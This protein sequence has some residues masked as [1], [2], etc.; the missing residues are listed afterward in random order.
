MEDNSVHRVG[1][2]TVYY[3]QHLI[4]C[5]I[6]TWERSLL[7]MMTWKRWLVKRMGHNHHLLV[8]LDSERRLD[9]LAFLNVWMFEMLIVLK[10]SQQWT[11]IPVG[12]F[13]LLD[14]AVASCPGLF[15][16]AYDWQL[17]KGVGFTRKWFTSKTIQEP[18][19]GHFDLSSNKKHGGRRIGVLRYD[20]L[21]RTCWNSAT[22][23]NISTGT[24][25]INC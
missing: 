13:S 15:F 11:K 18:R 9:K 3:P 7:S 14:L 20:F 5:L 21:C 19:L 8:R 1:P 24:T 22:M 17:S 23:H 4:L 16:V 12:C 10:Q 6:M 2:N 25:G